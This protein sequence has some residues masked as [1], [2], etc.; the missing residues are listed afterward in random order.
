MTVDIRPPATAPFQVGIGRGDRGGPDLRGALAR[1]VRRSPGG[2][3][4]V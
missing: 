3:T 2:A 1:P 4:T